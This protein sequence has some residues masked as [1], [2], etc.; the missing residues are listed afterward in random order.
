MM[1]IRNMTDDKYILLTIVI[2]VT[3]KT[4]TTMVMVMIIIVVIL[5]NRDYNDSNE[6]TINKIRNDDFTFVK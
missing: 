3:I 2:S 4:T 1:I 6:M 5:I